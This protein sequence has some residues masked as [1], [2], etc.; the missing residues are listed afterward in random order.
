MTEASLL[1]EVL[2]YAPQL[3]GIV[4]IAIL[5]LAILRRVLP[6]REERAE[7][8]QLNEKLF[9]LVRDLNG[10]QERHGQRL[11]DHERQ[12]DKHD[13]RIGSLEKQVR[14]TPN[15]IGT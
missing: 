1:K 10:K 8:R 14:V 3:G 2:D 12:L 4:L 15:S 11:D 6:N 13:H 9:D 5:N 7:Q